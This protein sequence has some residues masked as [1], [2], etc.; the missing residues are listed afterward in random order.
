MIIKHKITFVLREGVNRC[1][2]RVMNSIMFLFVMSELYL[3]ILYR[4][5]NNYRSYKQLHF[6]RVLSSKSVYFNILSFLLHFLG[7]DMT[8]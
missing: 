4:S 5:L 1:K 3:R 2:T 7:G 8:L 6:C